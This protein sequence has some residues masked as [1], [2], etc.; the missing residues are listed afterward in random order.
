MTSLWA[1]LA[2]NCNPWTLKLKFPLIQTWIDRSNLKDHPFPFGI[3]ASRCSLYILP[4]CF[5]R[6]WLDGID[7]TQNSGWQIF[8][9]PICPPPS[10]RDNDNSPRSVSELKWKA[11]MSQELLR[12]LPSLRTLL[13]NIPGSRS[14]VLLGSANYNEFA[15]QAQCSHRKL[16]LFSIVPRLTT[17][18]LKQYASERLSSPLT[19]RLF[20]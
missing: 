10:R 11:I 3:G 19:L 5:L 4:P 12:D 1:T 13:W 16:P 15:S 17:V 14:F 7:T 2:L 9:I 20:R 18:I 8:Q 6:S